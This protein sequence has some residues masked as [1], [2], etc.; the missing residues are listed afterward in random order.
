MNTKRWTGLALAILAAFTWTARAQVAKPRH[1][2]AKP[3]PGAWAGVSARERLKV[4]RVAELDAMRA[5]A[6]RVYG[7]RIEGGSMVY[8][9][10]LASDVVRTRLQALLKGARETEKAEY[11]ENGAVQIVYGVTLRD[12]VETIETSLKKRSFTYKRTVE[13]NDR[14]IE[15][16]GMAAIPGSQAHKE[17]LARRAAEVDAYRKMAE[18]VQGIRLESGTTVREY[19]VQNDHL[20]ATVAAYLRGLKPL[21][22]NYPGDGTCEVTVQL[23]RRTFIETVKTVLR[24]TKGLFRTKT[25]TT[26]NVTTDTKDEVITTTGRGTWKDEVQPVPASVDAAVDA[27]AATMESRTVIKRVLRKEVVVE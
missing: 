24:R 17:V 10:V 12:V 14:L 18:K 23:K 19:C 2:V 16:L 6:E 4:R 26:V 27:D 8:D 5:L 13:N 21:D 3:L 25:E 9:Y 15:A 22:V 1:G 11:L 7:F 20:R